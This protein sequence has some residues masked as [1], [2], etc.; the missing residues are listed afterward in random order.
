LT[1]LFHFVHFL[2]KSLFASTLPISIISVSDVDELP[3]KKVVLMNEIGESANGK[4]DG[5]GEIVINEYRETQ[6]QK[7]DDCKGC[8]RPLSLLE[9]HLHLL[10]PF[11]YILF[12]FVHFLDKSLFASTL[13]ISIIS[14]S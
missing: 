7:K 14:V 10:H 13:P 11:D 6:V 12:Q 9:V 5:D 1:I 3:T 8:D 4:T 2:D